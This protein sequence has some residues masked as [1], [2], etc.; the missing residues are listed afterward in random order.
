MKAA[1]LFGLIN[2]IN[3]GHL[4]VLQR[5]TTQTI[6][7]Y[8]EDGELNTDCLFEQRNTT[9]NAIAVAY[10]LEENDRVVITNYNRLPRDNQ[11]VN[12]ESNTKTFIVK[13]NGGLRLID[14]CIPQEYHNKRTE[15]QHTAQL[16]KLRKVFAPILTS[17][18]GDI[19][20]AR[21]LNALYNLP[22]IRISSS[23]RLP[24]MRN[25]STLLNTT[26]MSVTL[27]PV[28]DSFLLVSNSALT[29]ANIDAVAVIPYNTVFQT[30]NHAFKLEAFAFTETSDGAEHTSKPLM[31]K[32][33]L[34]QLYKA[35][36]YYHLEQHDRFTTIYILPELSSRAQ[37][38]LGV[39]DD[40]T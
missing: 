29:L 23:D 31:T 39:E 12:M 35:N 5:T 20:D 3:N 17:Q 33:F 6:R 7:V 11:L 4:W 15:L 8:H 30:T 14:T 10:V 38:L 1:K 37:K 26:G 18:C 36:M 16:N 22:S 32:Y 25:E 9:T 34:D 2:R 28:D 27:Q 19:S 13:L 21:N 24:A 40:Q